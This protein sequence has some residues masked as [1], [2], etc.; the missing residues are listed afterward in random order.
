MIENFHFPPPK[1]KEIASNH[2]FVVLS[3][4]KYLS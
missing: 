3:T 2:I 4:S 1:I